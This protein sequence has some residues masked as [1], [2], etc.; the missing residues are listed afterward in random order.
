MKVFERSYTLRLCK[1]NNVNT[2]EL[3]Q[4]EICII[5]G[6]EITPSPQL[7]QQIKQIEC[8]QKEHEESHLFMLIRRTSRRRDT[9]PPPIIM[10]KKILKFTREAS[11]H[12]LQ[13]TCMVQVPLT[14]F[15]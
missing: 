1:K 10:Q 7:C 9:P 13:I 14:T 3:I 5:V 6:A 12:K 11:G 4:S 8:R 15:K 2:S